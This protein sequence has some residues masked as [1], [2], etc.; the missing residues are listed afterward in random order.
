MDS[1]DTRCISY[2]L[3]SN[4]SPSVGTLSEKGK[5]L[6]MNRNPK[7]PH[8]RVNRY[9]EFLESQMV[10]PQIKRHYHNRRNHFCV[11]KTK[12]PWTRTCIHLSTVS[13]PLPQ[14]SCL[15]L[16]LTATKHYD[17]GYHLHNVVR[18]LRVHYRSVLTLSLY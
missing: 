12:I 11:E 3:T 1:S 5:F 7:A 13:D 2:L 16:K 9:I 8:L 15:H 6:L 4:R 17:Q 18:G 10:D 14:L